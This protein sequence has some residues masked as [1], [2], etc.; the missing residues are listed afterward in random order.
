MPLPTF[1]IV[2]GVL[3]CVPFGLAIRETVKGVERPATAEERMARELE[4]YRAE[5][6]ARAAE[7]EAEEAK[8]ETE[9]KE[10]HATVIKLVHGKEPATLGAA[11]DGAKLGG[12]ETDAKALDDKLGQ[13]RSLY[14]LDLFAL[15]DGV[16][17]QSVFVKPTLRYDEAEEFCTTLADSLETAWGDAKFD[18]H[19]RAIWI[20][21]PLEQRA[22]YDTTEGCELKI[23]KFAQVATWFDKSQT[24]IVPMWA[25]G[26]PAARLVSL[27]GE[28]ATA[29]ETEISWNGLGIGNGIGSTNLRAIVKNNRIV[30]IV[31]SAE[32]DAMSQD[33][34]YQQVS[35]VLGKEPDLGDDSYTWKTKPP[36]V[37]ETGS[38]QLTLTIGKLPEEE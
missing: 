15:G 36:V 22:I 11:F 23:E 1:T 6:E 14:E 28:R 25:I 10:K 24:S 3:T 19:N 17:F 27:L 30:A 34:V 29:D 5:R 31:A 32:T 16:T 7:W 21:G 2:M 38:A 33:A 37:L 13:M 18:L 9:R 4:A 26:Q 12:P 20:N 35:K 8:R